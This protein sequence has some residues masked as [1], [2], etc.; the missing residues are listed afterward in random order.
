MKS[1]TTKISGDKDKRVIFFPCE[2]I[3]SPTVRL[4]R[5]SGGPIGLNDL[6]TVSPLYVPK[7]N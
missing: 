5:K 2:R 1:L 3:D 4:E 6:A 7:S